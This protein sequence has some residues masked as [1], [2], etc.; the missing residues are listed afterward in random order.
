[1]KTTFLLLAFLASL[2]MPAFAQSPGPANALEAGQ[3]PAAQ[4][5]A[6]L[7]AALDANTAA[8]RAF[9]ETGFSASALENES[10]EQRTA[11]LDRLVR[12]AGRISIVETHVRSERHADVILATERGRFISAV[13][14]TS[15]REPGKI[16]GLFF[17]PA[18]DPS[19]TAREAWPDSGV[20]LEHLSHEIAWRI[21]EQAQDD[22]FYGAVL[23]ARRDE[24]LFHAAYG[25]ANVAAGTRNT[26]QTPFGS[27]SIGKMFTS[28]AILALI[29]QGRISLDDPITKWVPEY[30]HQAAGQRITLRHLLLHTSG[31]GDWPEQFRPHIS[32]RAAAT[33][34]TQ[35][36][37]AEPGARMSYNNANYVLLGAVL[38]AVTGRSLEEALRELV[39]RPANMTSTTLA[40]GADLRTGAIRYHFAEDD[41]VGFRGYVPNLGN[42]EFRADA[43][44]GAY[45]T[46]GDLF[47]FHRALYLGRL[48]SSQRTQEILS[49]V[50]DFPGTPRP[51][52]YGYGMRFSQCGT[53][54]VFGHSG[55]GPNA[56]VSNATYATSDGEWTIIVLSNTNAAG[57]ALA[58]ALC[59][60]VAEVR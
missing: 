50:V 24:I 36:P 29:D 49:P 8:R 34:M 7:V 5:A 33:T 15:G 43:S 48:L 18:R 37:N 1:M 47:A 44:G 54:E 17:L 45:T 27:A 10:A 39:F 35:A 25:P 20:A 59:E 14:F 6:A 26:V 53:R 13:V 19:K 12:D 2:E 38:E 52:R 57:E 40:S 28:V 31:I 11:F 41:P 56:G 3:N 58:I 51:S 4:A 21:E 16:S 42:H 55:G 22:F 23:V 46:I 9:V 32:Q 60:A 30:P